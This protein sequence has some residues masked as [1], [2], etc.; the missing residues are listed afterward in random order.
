MS[1]TTRII[2]CT[3][4]QVFDVLS[5]GWSYASWVVGAS[6]IRDVDEAWPA[7]GTR[8]QHSVGSWPLL[9]DDNTEV[10]EMSAPSLLQLRVKAWP[11]G[12]GRVRMTCQPAADGCEVVMEEEA[13]SGPA[14]LIPRPVQDAMLRARNV[15]ALKRLAFLA[16]GR[17]R[18]GDRPAR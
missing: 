8:I 2:H 13:V 15:E 17:A 16:E 3:P 5:D 1:R 14:V 9:I 18:N 7:V 10:E 11:T 6:R 12:E 4:E